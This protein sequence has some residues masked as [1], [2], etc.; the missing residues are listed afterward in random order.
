MK[1]LIISVIFMF[2]LLSAHSQVSKTDVLENLESNQSSDQAVVATA[3]LQS[4]SRLFRDK[5]DLTS[6]VLV[7]PKDAVVNVLESDDDY[8]LVEFQGEKGYIGTGHAEINIVPLASETENVEPQTESQDT[9][10]P[11]TRPFERQKVS[12]Y[13]YLEDKYGAKMAARIFAGKIWK[14]MNAE[15]VRDSWGSPR[16]INRIIS[17]NT[18]QEEWYFGGTC[19]YFQ[20]STLT[21]WGPA[22]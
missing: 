8:L 1:K 14:G 22:K 21:N 17:G 18:V 12:R 6:V 10:I 20:N 11:E 7:I 5:N 13:S 15:M 9:Y 3:T 4:A 19:L 16:E 2:I